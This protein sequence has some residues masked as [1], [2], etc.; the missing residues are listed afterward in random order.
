MDPLS[1]IAASISIAVGA[2][3]V[4]SSFIHHSRSTPTNV[5]SYLYK[6]AFCLDDIIS[7]VKDI[8]KSVASLSRELQSL[9]RA[10]TQAKDTLSRGPKLLLGPSAATWEHVE[11]VIKNC[12]PALQDLEKLLLDISRDKPIRTGILRKPMIALSLARRGHEI[13]EC[14]DELRSHTAAL[15]L[16]LAVNSAFVIARSN[17]HSRN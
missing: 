1:I 10:A 13:S 14:R 16:G 4:S 15:Q 6:A 17:L 3:R 2:G 9:Q 12:T 11:Q 8:D 7:K 5:S